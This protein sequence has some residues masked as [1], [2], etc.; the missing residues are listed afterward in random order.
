VSATATLVILAAAAVLAPV[1]AELVPRVVVPVVVL[2]IGLGILAGPV[3]GLLEPDAVLREVSNVGLAFLFFLAGMEIDSRRLAARPLV[4]AGAS[5]LLSLATAFAVAGLLV[6]AGLSLPIVF[7]AVILC[8]TALGT[9]LPILR[10][11]DVLPTRVGRHALAAG[12]CG[13]LFPILLTSV[14]LSGSTGRTLTGA[15]L[16]T[17]AVIAG[18]CAVIARR[19]RPPR[20]VALL[21]RSMHATSQLPVRLC[22]LVLVGLVALARDFGLDVILGAFAAGMVVR[23]ASPAGHSSVLEHK[24]EAIGFGVTVPFFFVASG[25]LF[26][27]DALAGNLVLVPVMLCALLVV[28]AVPSLLYRNR[29]DRRER[30]ALTLY[31]STSL[32]LVVAITTIAVAGGHMS[33]QIAAAMVAAGMLS[34][35][36]F[37]ML[38]LA[39]GGRVRTVA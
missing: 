4:L 22:V 27:L 33:A 5:W 19:V 11:A 1:V 9:L 8:T 39:L 10:D 14:V 21:S 18:A 28:H 16:L 29:L 38:A 7:V 20:V 23:T 34:V 37:P 35:L 32:P 12:L 3:L 25:V 26:D 13:E 24:L 6:A 31:S 15:L 2:E 30:L 36:L 17:F